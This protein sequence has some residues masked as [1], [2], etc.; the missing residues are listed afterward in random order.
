M[1]SSIIIKEGTRPGKTVAIFG[2]IHGNE[3]VGIQAIDAVLKSVDIESGKVYF[4]H[5]NL[6]AIKRNIRFVEKNLNRLFFE[7][8]GGN[9]TEDARA[10]DLMR[11]LDECDALLDIHAFNDERGKPFI[12]CEKNS[13]ELAQQLQ[14]PIISTG[15]ATIEPNS[16]DGYMFRKGKHALCLECGSVMNPEKYLPLAIE[17]INHFLAYFGCIKKEKTEKTNKERQHIVEVKKIIRKETEKFS[18]TKEFENF[19]TL[20]EGSVFAHDDQKQYIAGKNECIIFPRPLTSIGAEAC[21][22][23]SITEA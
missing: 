11:I 15:W 22:I 14:F 12:I 17:S 8:N 3:T 20:T 9:T 2:G 4:V 18:F 5:S 1:D 6:E 23:G 10:R 13:F 7:N 19:E 21:V 16:T